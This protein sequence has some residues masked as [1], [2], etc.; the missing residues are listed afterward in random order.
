MRAWVRER[1][2]SIEQLRLEDVAT[3]V[4]RPGEVLVQ[5][6]A[7]SVNLSDWESLHGSPGYARFGG[8]RRILGSDVAGRVSAIGPGVT[9]FRVGDEVYGDSMPRFGGFAE[10]IA[11]PETELAAMPAGLGFAEASAIPQAGAIAREALALAQPGMRLLVNGAGGGSGSLV[12]QLA[13]AKGL[14]VT[15]VDNAGKLDFLRRLGAHDV[16][17]YR[18]SDPFRSGPYD[19]IVDMVALRSVFTYRRALARGGRYVMV[20]G[21]LRALFRM[22]TIGPLIGALTGRRLGLLIVHTGP[23]HFA[24][25]GE[26]IA[27]GEVELHIDREFPFAELPVALALHGEGKA[28]GKVIVRVRAEG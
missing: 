19:L 21:T 8:L 11:M 28:L 6:V 5:V 16:I 18:A 7:A 10:Y 9:H 20:G 17:D 25:L 3:P 1:Y 12:V 4:P 26:R 24:E 15:A 13:V 27:A 14:R 2:G 22:V 23:T